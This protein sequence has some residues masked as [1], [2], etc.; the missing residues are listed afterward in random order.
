M[1]T[2]RILQ[3]INHISLAVL[4]AF[5]LIFSTN[6]FAGTSLNKIIAIVNDD[7]ITS[8]DLDKAY[9][10]LLARV[11]DKSNLPPKSVLQKQVL[12][13]LILDRLQLQLAEKQ[14]IYIA[15]EDINNTAQNI[16][17]S[18]NLTLQQLKEDFKQKGV[19]YET[20]RKQVKNELTISEIQQREIGLD[21][22]VS[23]SEI[24]SFIN[25]LIDKKV[26]LGFV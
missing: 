19:S 3:R 8:I 16:A 5:S 18:E 21:T 17:K 1:S 20:F 12:N 10:F 22:I 24:E 2:R 26:L 23:E 14:D 25:K 15:P 6:C 13:K 9:S 11:K 7:A 4:M